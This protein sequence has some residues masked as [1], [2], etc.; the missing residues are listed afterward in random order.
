[1]VDMDVKIIPTEGSSGNDENFEH[2]ELAKQVEKVGNTEVKA[3]TLVK[4]K[5]PNFARLVATHSFEDILE[6]NKNEDVIIPADL[7]ADLA[8]ADLVDDEQ[9]KRVILVLGGV[10]LGVLI[11]F[12]FL[13]GGA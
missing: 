11:A 5:F 3:T 8:N 12:V 9:K 10:V 13:G 4:M 6:K 1:M 2:H 7:I